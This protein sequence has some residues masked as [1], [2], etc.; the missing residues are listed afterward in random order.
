MDMFNSCKL[1][2]SKIYYLDDEKIVYFSGE[3]L[4]KIF[5][6]FQTYIID[7]H[8]YQSKC[9]EIVKTIQAM[10]SIKS[11]LEVQKIALLIT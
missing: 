3:W 4:K 9:L 6:K 2:S 7:R 5:T 10:I 11:L 1:F 8:L